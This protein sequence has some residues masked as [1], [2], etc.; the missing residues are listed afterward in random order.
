[1]KDHKANTFQVVPWRGEV[2][3]SEF[4]PP[5]QAALSISLSIGDTGLVRDA[6]PRQVPRMRKFS[7]SVGECLLLFLVGLFP[8]NFCDLILTER[9]VDVQV[10]WR[11]KRSQRS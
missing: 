11:R 6:F 2:E 10:L 7:H 3:L 1:V 4:I 8:L 5:I 9:I